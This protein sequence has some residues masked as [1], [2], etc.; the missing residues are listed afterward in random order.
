MASESAHPE[1]IRY[2]SGVTGPGDPNAKTTPLPTD[3]MDPKVPQENA[4]L[5]G[6]FKT[7]E[8]LAN[9]YV[10]LEK[11]FHK[12]GKSVDATAHEPSAK[13]ETAS[14]EENEDDDVS[15]EVGD[16]LSVA[17]LDYT[18]L[19]DEYAANG[20]LSDSSYAALKKAGIPKGLVDS[21]ISG[22]EAA[23]ARERETAEA[24]A[25][26]LKG[27]AGGEDGYAALVSWAGNTL[28]E[29][30]ITAFNTAVNSG[31]KAL[32]AMAIRG[33]VDTYS[34]EVG[35]SPIFIGG[36][37]AEDADIFNSTHEMTAAMSDPRYTK[38]PHYR[39][40]VEAKVVRSRLRQNGRR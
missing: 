37:A 11:A 36:A 29:D 24:A 33:L 16:V 38:D 27:L 2:V 9:A 21:Y 32:A 6:K 8:D 13:S 17:G 7:Q 4:L 25:T 22:Q 3:S 23:L 34:R 35:S 26:E 19:A 14:S 18:K 28:S 30:E 31:N 20:R 5:L 15:D 12:K 40:Q 1:D 39:R 10:E